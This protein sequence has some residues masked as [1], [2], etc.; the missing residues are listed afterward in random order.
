MPPASVTVNVFV[1]VPVGKVDP[2]GRPAVCAVVAPGQLSV[3]IGAIY[4]TSA[5]H[6]PGAFHCVMFPGH[7]IT[8]ACE[9]CDCYRE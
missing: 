5:P 3:P 9:S 7:V 4:I 2:L 6:T 8:G 1:V